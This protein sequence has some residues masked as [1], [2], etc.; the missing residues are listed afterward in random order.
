MIVD[1]NSAFV[2]ASTTRVAVDPPF[3][4]C[5][6]YNVQGKMVGVPPEEWLLEALATEFKIQG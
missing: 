6:T 3:F 5:R 4:G 1:G 2:V